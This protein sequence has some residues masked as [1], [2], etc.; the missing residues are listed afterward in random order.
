MVVYR[1]GHI[2]DCKILYRIFK[3]SLIIIWIDPQRFDIAGRVSRVLQAHQRDMFDKR[4]I[5][6]DVLH[7]L[8]KPWDR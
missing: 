7:E 8:A 2:S 5:A 4:E 1:D 3:L 6:I